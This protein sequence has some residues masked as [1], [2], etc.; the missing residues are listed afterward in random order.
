MKTFVYK[1]CQQNTPLARRREA[2]GEVG[3]TCGTARAP[4]DR[5]RGAGGEGCWGSTG[6][7]EEEGALGG[8]AQGVDSYRHSAGKHRA[9]R[10]SCFNEKML[11]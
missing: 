11:L 8:P 2:W 5:G 3:L 6:R 4:A 9:E 7:E 1:T 10:W